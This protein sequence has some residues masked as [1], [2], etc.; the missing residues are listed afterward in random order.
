MSIIAWLTLV[1]CG[2]KTYTKGER[3]VKFPPGLSPLLDDIETK[4][5]KLPPIFGVRLLMEL[6]S[7]LW[8]ET[9][10][11]KSSMAVKNTKYLY[12]SS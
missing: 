6:F 9:G 10:S 2:K 4:F 12:L 5:Q 3:G 11:Q 1:G 8:D 7:S